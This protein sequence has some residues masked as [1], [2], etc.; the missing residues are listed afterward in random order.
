M[1]ILLAST[2]ALLLTIVPAHAQLIGGGALGGALG[3]TLNGTLGGTLSGPGSLGSTMDTVRSP[4]ET[5][6][7]AAR[8][9]TKSSARTAGSQNVNARSGTVHADRSANAGLTGTA[10]G[11]LATPA[12]SM[13]GSASAGGSGSAA[14]SANAQL[15]GTD[16]LTQTAASALTTARSTASDAAMT[17]RSTTGMLGS[18][19]R[20]TAGSAS[21]AA[22]GTASGSAN[23]LLSGTSGNLAAA[24]SL[25]AA[26]NGAISVS[27]GMSVLGPDGHRLGKVRSVIA[28]AHGEVQAVLVKVDGA[29]ATLPA[30][31]FSGEGTALI[32]AMGKSQI[33]QQQAASNSSAPKKSAPA[34]ATDRN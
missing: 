34:R 24:G 10:A 3:G 21:S 30:A 13:A 26:G 4:V 33:K 29:T 9:N 19:A 11:A 12:Q 5:V 20:Q 1:K 8:A 25:A 2:T 23:G 32:S 16:A 14:G 28:D 31:N 22:T 18:A 17:A 15:L 6:G 27:R 7:S